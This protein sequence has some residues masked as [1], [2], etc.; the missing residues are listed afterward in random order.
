MKRTYL[1]PRIEIWG[2][3]ECTYNRVNDTYFDQVKYSGHEERDEDIG[4][5][6][7]LGIRRMRYPILW[8][9]LQPAPDTIIS[10]E[11]V[12]K[13]LNQLRDSGVDPIAGLVHHGSGPVYSNVLDD[14]FPDSLADY[15]YKVA[16][17]FPWIQYY[18]PI[19]EPLTTARFCGLYGIWHP[20]KKRR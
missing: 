1:N 15:A 9:K 13:K 16:E 7:N 14:S 18:T 19:N 6:A 20:H 12:E 2:G 8:E 3:I 5:F 11:S 17:K 10:W 4:L